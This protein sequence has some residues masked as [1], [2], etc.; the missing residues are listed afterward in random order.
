MR[1]RTFARLGAAV[2]GVAVAGTAWAAFATE[3]GAVGNVQ[4]GYWS[5]YPAAP[6]VPSGGLEVSSNADGPASV[7]AIRFTLDSGEKA[8]VLKLKV[9]QA[10]PQS[11][12]SIQA[13]QVADKS[14]SW[15]PPSGGGPGQMADA[16]AADCSAG[17]IVAQLASDGSTLTVDFSS[18]AV[19]GSTVDIVLQPNQ[20]AN[21]AGALPNMPPSIWPTFDVALQPVTADQITVVKGPSSSSSGLT[22]SSGNTSGAGA[23]APAPAAAPAV[24]LPPSTTTTSNVGSAPVVAGSPQSSPVAQAAPVLLTKKRNLR[25]LFAIAMLSSDLLFVFMWVQRRLPEGEGRPPLS[26]Y[27]PP[28][29][30]AAS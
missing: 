5:S 15:Q 13:C 7:A 20:I 1:A 22:S 9:A 14:A 30:V 26:I 8:P 28:P 12:V 2:C 11:Q 27:D 19:T 4:S 17:L 29:P 10:Q 3:A 23:P 18:V 16:P 24:Q 6:Q 25:L 21:P